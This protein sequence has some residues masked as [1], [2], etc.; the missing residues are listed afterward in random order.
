MR[1]GPGSGS[2]SSCAPSFFFNSATA[3]RH[4]L[5]CLAVAHATGAAP[6]LGFGHHWIWVMVW[7]R[8]FFLFLFTPFTE[9]CTRHPSSATW[10]RHR[11]V[12]PVWSLFFVDYPQ[13]NSAKSLPSIR[14]GGLGKVRFAERVRAEYPLAEYNTRQSLCRVHMGLSRVFWVLGKNNFSS[15]VRACLVPWVH[16]ACIA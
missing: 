2:S 7:W 3:L 16:L 13:M 5:G 1:R 4:P 15:S 8:Y 12:R 9:W 6:T 10:L 14:Q 11:L